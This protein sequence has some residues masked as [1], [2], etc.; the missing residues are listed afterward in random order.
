MVKALFVAPFLLF[1][2]PSHANT[3]QQRFQEAV[4]LLESDPVLAQRL[5]ET[6]YTETLSTRVKLE[7]ARAAY[8]S[9]NYTRAKTLFEQVL[10]EDLPLM[11]RN[12][13]ESFL[14]ELQPHINPLS[15]SL[16]LI[17]DTNP[18]ASPEQ[19]EVVIFGQ[20]FNYVPEVEKRTETGVLT[21]INY[22]LTQEITKVV[23][24]NIHLD[25][26]DYPSKTNDRL[27]AKFALTRRPNFNRN[28][29]FGLAAENVRLG[30]EDL[31]NLTSLSAEYSKSL[32]NRLAFSLGVKRG[33]LRYK[34][35]SYLNA[36]LNSFTGAIFF[37]VSPF[38]ALIFEGGVV[39]SDSSESQYSYDEKHVAI[40]FRY[41]NTPT[42][43]EVNVKFSD[44]RRSYDGQDYLFGEDRRDKGRAAV[45]SL[46]KRDVYFFGFRPHLD[47]QYE[48]VDSNIPLVTFDKSLF[49][50]SFTRVF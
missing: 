36:H 7:W 42:N 47:Y 13:V 23:D 15:I 20:R 49:G 32:N 2:F 19:Q 33:Q 30:S 35:Y 3:Y 46:S 16:S 4:I 31:Y 34:Q 27:I 39:A 26:F 28:F 8:L 10:S 48:T 50:L 6:L 44:R 38:F 12:N 1:A 22:R 18:R 43:I 25:Y 24:V 14:W 45:V 11:V 9:G 41:T 5:L 37:D 17:R 40:G 29:R 21:A